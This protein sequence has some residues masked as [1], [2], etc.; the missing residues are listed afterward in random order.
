M[1][2]EYTKMVLKNTSD[3]WGGASQI[4]VVMQRL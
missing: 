3:H 1:G 4:V 2:N